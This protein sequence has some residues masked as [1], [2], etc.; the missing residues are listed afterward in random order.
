MISMMLAAARQTGISG[1]QTLEI[2]K[3]TGLLPES[4]ASVEPL[5]LAK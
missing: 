2:A 4:A 1:E 3:S 5:K